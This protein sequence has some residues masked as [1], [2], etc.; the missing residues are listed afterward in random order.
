MK[1]LENK[2][3][4]MRD[5]ITIPTPVWGSSPIQD[6]HSLQLSQWLQW[7]PITGNLTLGKMMEA[8]TTGIDEAPPVEIA[9]CYETLVALYHSLE[10]WKLLF[11]SHA[12]ANDANTFF[13]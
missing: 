11:A 10:S 7:M 3:H 13:A 5:G 12:Q 2:L 8:T 9:L 6:R 1:N 4:G